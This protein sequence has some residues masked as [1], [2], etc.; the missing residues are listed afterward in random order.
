M[1]T[2]VITRIK[3]M[4]AMTRVVCS[5]EERAVTRWLVHDAPTGIDRA[6]LIEQVVELLVRYLAR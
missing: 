6:T 1:T 4:R 3:N 5:P 2:R